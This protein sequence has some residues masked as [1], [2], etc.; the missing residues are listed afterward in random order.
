MNFEG[1]EFTAYSI[2]TTNTNVLL[3]EAEKGML[4]CGYLNIEIANK[5]N[6][7]C[8]IVTGVKTPDDMLS[9]KVVAVSN[10]AAKMGIK[11]GMTG[12]E[13]LLLMS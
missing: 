9:A 2:P 6:D 3:I 7:V 4:G 12:K 13:A 8:A 11:E 5:V 1:K 10:E